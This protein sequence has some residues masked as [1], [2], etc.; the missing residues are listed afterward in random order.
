MDAFLAAV[1][2]G[3]VIKSSPQNVYN[4]AREYS[5]AYVNYLGMMGPEN[6]REPP[7]SHTRAFLLLDAQGSRLGTYFSDVLSPSE[8]VQKIRT[9]LSA[10]NN[11]APDLGR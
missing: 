4:S 3:E 7:V 1:P 2:E 6:W 8:I 9:E 5:I 11:S 10:S